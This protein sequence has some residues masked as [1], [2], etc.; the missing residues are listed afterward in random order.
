MKI[1]KKSNWQEIEPQVA[2][3]QED[4]LQTMSAIQTLS[5]ADKRLPEPTHS[6]LQSKKMILNPSFNVVVCGEVKKGKSSLLNAIVGKQYLPVNNEIATSQVFR[7]ANSDTESF[8]IVF[9][10]GSKTPITKEELSKY[11]SQVDADLQGEP[12]FKDKTLSYIQL[13]IPVAF[14]PEGV[15][16]V[17]TPGLGALYKSHEYITQN[18]IKNASAVIFVLDPERPIVEKEKEAIEKIISVTPNILFVMTKI[19]L[20]SEEHVNDILTRDEELLSLIFVEHKLQSPEIYP[21]SNI[22]LQKASDAK[23]EVLK[24]A[25][26]KNSKFP[27][28]KN[29]LMLLIYKSLGLTRT[30]FAL[31][32]SAEQ[33]TKLKKIIS[34]VLLVATQDNLNAQVELRKEKDSRKKE[35]EETWKEDS[36]YYNAAKAQ[37]SDECHRV[38]RRVEQIFS[39]TG[40]VYQEYSKKIDGLTNLE[41]AK[42]LG[43]TLPKEVAN[44]LMAQWKSIAD[45]AQER[46][47]SIVAKV[48]AEMDKQAYGIDA[49]SSQVDGIAISD[50]AIKDKIAC[51]R[52]QYFTGS[53]V[54]GIGSAVLV[55]MGFAALPVA[56]IALAVT[57]LWGWL[58]GKNDAQAKAL[59]KTKVNFKK[60]LND[61]FAEIRGKL[62]QVNG[63]ECYSVVEQYVK[64]LSK[65]ALEAMGNLLK[66]KQEI[67]NKQIKELEAQTKT[68]NAER[69][70]TEQKW[71]NLKA[72]CDK[73][74]TQIKAEVAQRER[75]SSELQVKL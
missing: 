37:I 2:K 36:K 35:L 16:L 69:R 47:F 46:V 31:R 3:L 66:D 4:I 1:Q 68:D 65:S 10:D 42:K 25:N 18:Y 64:D 40:S 62:L 11:G 5:D 28:V 30:G 58:V 13:N 73:I 72:S 27:E 14:L 75:I 60:A 71:S 6:F 53:W 48:G 20:Y 59:E 26:Y 70:A 24:K 61:E 63:A 57:T 52:N 12:V 54:S 51:Y 7:I 39:Q 23:I 38:S 50:L 17:D 43:E 41:D 33:T 44:D 21:V 19:D 74:I 56:V 22:S 15:N 45:E 8:S 29:Q 67:I 55:S 32:E 49:S 34:E 9:N